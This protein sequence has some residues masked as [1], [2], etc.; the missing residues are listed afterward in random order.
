MTERRP[1]QWPVD[2][3]NHLTPVPATG[4][5]PPQDPPR[6]EVPVPEVRLVAVV[7]LTGQYG[8]ST[9]VMDDLHEQTKRSTDCHTAIV[10]L[11]ESALQKASGFLGHAIASKFFLAAQQIEV[12][13]PA[14]TRWAYVASEVQRHLRFFAADHAR[15][16]TNL[17]NPG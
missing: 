7:N 6:I 14:G 12:H 4:E 3:P 8:T 1:G 15:M 13:V 10:Q 9:E 5:Q 16:L 17:R 11:G 2:K